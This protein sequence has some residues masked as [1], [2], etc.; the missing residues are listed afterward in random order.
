MYS[1]PS[2][3]MW[4]LIECGMRTKKMHMSDLARR[5]GV[6]PNTIT[7]DSQ[8]PERIPQGRLWLYFEAVGVP[9]DEVI[10]ATITEC[11]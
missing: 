10:S 7:R 1:T 3:A 6:H 2:R 5:V 8:E 9:V 11:I 4:S